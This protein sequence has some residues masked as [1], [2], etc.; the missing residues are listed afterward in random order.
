MEQQCFPSL[1]N[2]KKLL[3]SF[4]KIMKYLIKMKTQKIVNFLNSSENGY[5]KFAT[6]YGTL[7]TVKKGVLIRITIRSSF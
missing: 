5:S 2:Q 3:F 4:C 1:K 6:K 7:L